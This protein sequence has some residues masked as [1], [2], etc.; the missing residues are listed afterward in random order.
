M[1]MAHFMKT[2]N[3][4]MTRQA[5]AAMWFQWIPCPLNRKVMMTVNTMRDMTS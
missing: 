5:N 4:A 3:T 1:E 2:K